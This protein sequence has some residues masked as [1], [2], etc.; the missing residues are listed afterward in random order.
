[1]Q[2]NSIEFNYYWK[3]A[4]VYENIKLTKQVWKQSLRER[5]GILIIIIYQPKYRIR[6][7]WSS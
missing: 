2:K 5:E 7:W 6:F 4:A 3:Q 1:M